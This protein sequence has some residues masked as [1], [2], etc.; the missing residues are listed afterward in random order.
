MAK[1]T[2]KLKPANH[3]TRPAS[4]KARK[5]KRAKVRT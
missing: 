1:N 4:S 2:R 5:A 3:G